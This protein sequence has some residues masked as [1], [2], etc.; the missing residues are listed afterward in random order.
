MA[1]WASA[2][3]EVLAIG[4]I[5]LIVF[6]SIGFA[7]LERFRGVDGRAV[8]RDWRHRM[9]RGILLGLEFLIAADIIRTVAIEMN[10]TTVG[11][12][13]VVVVVRTFLSFALEVELSGSW[14]WRREEEL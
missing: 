6:S 3:V 11:V 2:I 4:M 12:L 13:A 9:G 8:M 1:E 7:V 10:F 5:V 14:P